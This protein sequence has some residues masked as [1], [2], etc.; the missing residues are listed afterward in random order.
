MATGNVDSDKEKVVLVFFCFL[1]LLALFIV[2]APFYTAMYFQNKSN[3]GHF[4]TIL[5]FSLVWKVVEL[6]F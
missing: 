3:I 5:Q 1:F 6:L 4:G 2:L